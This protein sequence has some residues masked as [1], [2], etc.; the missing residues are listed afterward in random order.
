MILLYTSNIFLLNDFIRLVII[1]WFFETKISKNRNVYFTNH[2]FIYDCYFVSKLKIE[3]NKIPKITIKLEMFN[4]VWLS[5]YLKNPLFIRIVVYI[6]NL[7]K[8]LKIVDISLNSV[9]IYSCQGGPDTK[10]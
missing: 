6:K 5:I 8:F 7:K 9:I 2:A 3:Y 4:G 1:L 10:I